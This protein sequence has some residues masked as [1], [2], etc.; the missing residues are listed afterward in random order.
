MNT[1]ERISVLDQKVQGAR[2]KVLGED[3]G[4]FSLV[5]WASHR[6]P[7][8]LNRAPLFDVLLIP[9][10]KNDQILERFKQDAFPFAGS[11]LGGSSETE[12]ILNQGVIEKGHTHLQGVG[13]ASERF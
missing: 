9:V 11:R 1:A 2:C 10:F 4:Q 6:E 8:A 13:H 7:C 3:S 5:P 12:D